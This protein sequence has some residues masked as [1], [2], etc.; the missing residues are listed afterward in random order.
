MFSFEKKK[1]F[2]CFEK[3]S[4]TSDTRHCWL[5]Y[6]NHPLTDD[7]FWY[8]MIELA[9]YWS[10]I[11]SQ[12]IDVKRKDFWEMFLHHIATTLL[13]S[14]SYIV[15]FVRIGA[16]V[17]AIHDFGDFWLEVRDELIEKNISFSHFQSAKIAKYARAQKICD[18]LFVIFALVWFL[19][20]LCYY[21]Y[22]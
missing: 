3:K 16:L 19:T 17:L 21:P 8:Y 9:F 12:F 15:N 20:R 5:N 13:L 10:L 7:M 22:K 4:W 2:S 6:P 11:F 18:T 1:D 14:F